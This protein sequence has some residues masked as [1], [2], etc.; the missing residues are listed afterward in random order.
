MKNRGLAGTHQHRTELL[1]ELPTVTNSDIIFLGN[2]LTQYCEWSE[3][4]QNTNIKNRGIAGDG[5]E[6]V[7]KRLPKI[8][9]GKP[10]AIFLMI[11]VNDLFYHD[12]K[13]ITAFYEKILDLCKSKSKETSVVVQSLLPVNNEIKKIQIGNE[14]I[15]ELNARIKELA[16]RFNYQFIDLNK[17]FKNESGK[18]NPDFSVDGIHINGRGYALWRDI[19]RKE[20][21]FL[22]NPKTSHK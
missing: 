15:E 4:F 9:D 7:L 1:D 5:V 17:E 3:V 12:V 20:F 11:G 6:G 2:S 22:Y 10:K 19:L 13:F 16:E 8:L 18:L 14:S 21:D